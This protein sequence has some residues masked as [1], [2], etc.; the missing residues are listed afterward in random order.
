MKSYDETVDDMMRFLKSKDVCSSS[1]N[2]HRSCYQKF[3]H[4]M[5]E[6]GKQWEPDAVSDCL[7]CQAL[8]L[9]TGIYTNFR[10]SGTGIRNQSVLMISANQPTL[11]SNV[12]NPLFYAFL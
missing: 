5:H 3:Q 7:E 11:I 4:F 6:H 8:A 1:I 12:Q 2:S 9:G 10:V